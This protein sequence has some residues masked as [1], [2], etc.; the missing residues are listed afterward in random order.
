METSRIGRLPIFNVQPVVDGG[1]FAAKAFEGEVI[2]FSATVFREGHDSLGA[3]LLLTSPAGKTQVIRMHAGAPGS[4]RWHAKAQVKELG[5]YTFQIRA[6]GDD[7]DT[8]HHSAA[9]KVAAGMDEEL[10]MLEGIALFT[11]AASEKGRTPANAKALVELAEKLSD[12]KRSAKA[13]LAEAEAPAILKLIAAQ[14]IRSLETLS[15]VHEL[16]V[17][18]LRAG[19]GAWY[20]FFP[21]SEGAKFDVKTKK[22][23]SGSFKT[24][25]KR[26]AAVKAMGFDVLYMPPIHP[27]GVAFRKGP[28]NTLNAVGDDPGSPWAIGSS[29]GGHDAIHPDLGDEK[30]FAA[31]M[32]EA[33]KVGL[34]VALDLALQASPDHPWVKEHPEWFT[35]RADGSIAY[36]ENPPKKY[37]DIYPINFDNDH[38]GI[39]SEVLRVVELWISRGVKIFRVDNPHTKPVNFWEWLIGRVNE[40]HPDV[41]FLAEAFTRPAMM[42]TLGKAGFQQ[43]YTYFSWRNS[44]QE[45]RAYLTE[46]AYESSNFFR[47]NFWPTTPDILPEYLQY[48]GRPAHKIR[49]AIAATAVPSWGMYAGYELVE[50]VARPGV[51]EHIDSEKYEYKPRDYAAAEKAGASIAPYITKLNAIRATHPALAQLR[52]IEFHSSDD[53]AILVYSKHLAAEHSPT[54][55]ADTIIVVVNTDPHAVR[56]TTVTLDL[57]KLDLPDNAVFEVTDLITDETWQWGTRNYVRLDAFVEPV[58]ILRVNRKK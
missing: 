20:E 2:P 28:N 3:E 37:Q 54:G 29:A 42:H 44:T 48:G 26:L 21:R 31:F 33:A 11:R 5:T 49:A 27:I 36:A 56:E 47:P 9:I 8:W 7:Y 32:K 12:K 18:R 43:S 15:E 34:E 6:F 25:A 45:L 22:W 13:R 14:P 57:W 51:E 4:D 23:T 53:G 40:K 1:L 35:T 50:S 55:K 10:M 24:A 17:E 52:N 46:V 41:V 38:D 39:Y 58:H 30:D 19:F 16:R